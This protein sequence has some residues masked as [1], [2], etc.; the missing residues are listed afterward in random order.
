MYPKSR[1]NQYLLRHI[2]N[3]HLL[4]NLCACIFYFLQ[5][6]FLPVENWGQ[7]VSQWNHTVHGRLL[8]SSSTNNLSYSLNNCQ[9]NCQMA[10]LLNKCACLPA[11]WIF[12]L[13]DNNYNG[14]HNYTI[15]NP[16]LLHNCFKG[17][18]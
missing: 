7:C 15:C 9:T 14:K 5:S 4:S 10:F 13:I 8:F 6:S 11:W 17:E 3:Y 16:L 1:F 12:S 18:K 2:K